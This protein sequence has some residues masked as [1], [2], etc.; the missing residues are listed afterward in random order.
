M[1]HGLTPVFAGEDDGVVKEG[2]MGEEFLSA[3]R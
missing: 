1:S 3:D 2:D